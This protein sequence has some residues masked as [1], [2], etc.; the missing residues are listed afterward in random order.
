MKSMKKNSDWDEIKSEKK[1]R[2][3]TNQLDVKVWLRSCD[4]EITEPVEGI[5]SGEIPTWINGSLLRNGPG[6]LGFGGNSFKH[7]FDAAALLHRFNIANGKVTY[8]CRFLNSE[9]YKKNLAAN[10]IVVTEFATAAVPDPCQSIFSRFVDSL[11]SCPLNLSLD[12]KSLEISLIS[13]QAQ[14]HFPSIRLRQRFGVRL[15]L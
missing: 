8:Q 13:Q 2:E 11:I 3:E 4:H 5:V 10:R 1:L 15:S 7:L 9:S 14:L 12:S 6:K